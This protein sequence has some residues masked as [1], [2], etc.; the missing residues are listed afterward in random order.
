MNPAMRF[1]WAMALASFVGVLVIARPGFGVFAFDAI[2][3]L[4]GAVGLAAFLTLTRA[5]SRDDPRVTAF[6]PVGGVYPV[7]HRHAGELG[8]A[9]RAPRTSHCLPPSAC[10]PQGAQVLQTLAYRHGSTHRIAP[11]SYDEPGGLHRCGLVGVSRRARRLVDPR[12][13]D[14][15]RRRRGDGLEKV[16]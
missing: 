15:C 6:R 8:G 4:V 9:Q 3:P 16:I 12:H 11:Y 2:Y 13:G 14:H 7:F 10:W 5:V 1:S